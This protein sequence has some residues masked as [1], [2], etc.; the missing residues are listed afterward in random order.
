MVPHGGGCGYCFLVRVYS[1]RP[2]SGTIPQGSGLETLKEECNEIVTKLQNVVDETRE[3]KQ[4]E[5]TDILE[6]AFDFRK[7]VG[8]AQEFDYLKLQKERKQ[9]PHDSTVS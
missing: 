6:Q 3:T 8:N 5:E 9:R 4:K 7:M 1:T 2:G